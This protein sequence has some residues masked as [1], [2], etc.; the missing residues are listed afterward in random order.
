MPKKAE[1]TLRSRTITQQE[2]VMNKLSWRDSWLDPKT[3]EI[4]EILYEDEGGFLNFFYDAKSKRQIPYVMD[5]SQLVTKNSYSLIKKKLSGMNIT[6]DV[7]D[8][9]PNREMT[10]QID[11]KSLGGSLDD[12]LSEINAVFGN[13]K[14]CNCEINV[15]ED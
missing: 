5:A 8:D 2:K 12:A 1:I 14:F 6:H 10:I 3:G 4:N 15:L 7:I 11:E 9:I 13:S